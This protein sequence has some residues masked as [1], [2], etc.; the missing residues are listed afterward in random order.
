MREMMLVIS[1]DETEDDFLDQLYSWEEMQNV[2]LDA[3]IVFTYMNVARTN[4]F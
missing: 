1:D 2:I 3:E 4:M